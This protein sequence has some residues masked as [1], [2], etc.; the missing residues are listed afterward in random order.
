VA[1]SAAALA[2]AVL[3][4]CVSVPASAECT[5]AAADRAWLTQ[6][7]TQWQVTEASVLKL[8]PQAL[9]QVIA[10]DADCTYTIPAGDLAV[11]S[12]V[13]HGETVQIP[14]GPELPVGPISF[15]NGKDAFI[16]SLPSVWRAAGVESEVGLERLMSGV[17]LHEM[18]HVRQ[19]ALANAA[20]DPTVKAHGLEETLSDD[21]LQEVFEPDADYAATFGAERDLFYA[22]AAAQGDD[23]A[24]RLAAEGLRLLRERRAKFFTGDKAYFTELDDVFLTM[25]GMGQFLIYTYFRSPEGGALNEAAAV[26]AVRRGRKWWSQDE[27]LALFLVLDRLLPDWQQRGFSEP[28]WRAQN[29]LAAALAQ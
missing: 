25:E 16:M 7:L 15:A 12:A 8:A 18:M 17:L 5:M 24:R 2:A 21:L 3:A 19:T 20:L 10:I 23:E 11:M 29:L 9:P 26:N 1:R 14:G 4:G 22:A 6:A 13:P 27:G 28:D